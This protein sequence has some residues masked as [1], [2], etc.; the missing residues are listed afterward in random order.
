[1][2]CSVSVTKLSCTTTEIR[3]NFPIC[4]LAPCSEAIKEMTR[5]KIEQPDA[6]ENHK[7]EI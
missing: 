7:S 4:V 6:F 3:A 2:L 1:M 5:K